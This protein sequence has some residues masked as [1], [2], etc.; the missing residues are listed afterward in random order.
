MKKI[1]YIPSYNY[2]CY[3]IYLNI[4][5]NAKNRF[6]NIFFNT[7]DPLFSSTNKKD[8]KIDEIKKYFDEYCEVDESLINYWN[9]SDKKIRKFINILTNFIKLKKHIEEK[10]DTINPDAILAGTDMGGYTIR[11]CNNWAEKNKIP[12]IIIQTAFFRDEPVDIKTKL[13]NRFFYFLFNTLLSIPLFQRQYL[14]GNEKSNNYLFLWGD[15]FKKLYKGKKIEKNIFITGN[16]AFDPLFKQNSIKTENLSLN[17]PKNKPIITI[18]TQSLNKFLDKK[19]IQEVEI[20]YR[21]IIKDNHDL[22]FIIKIHPREDIKYYKNLFGDINTDNFVIVKNE[23]IYN[24][25]SVTDIQISVVSYSSF[26]AVI[27][28]IPIILVK[29]DLISFLDIFNNEIELNASNLQQLNSSIKKCLTKEYKKKYKKKRV[30]YLKSKL[31]FID[32]KSSYRVMKNIEKI[33]NTYENN[34][35]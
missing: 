10:L 33:V 6:F 13:K 35:P 32:G 31:G 29:K 18:C 4:V 12:F 14:Y 17:L 30:T 20:L 25:Y 15:E 2:L 8:I 21:K 27:F 16:P 22:F 34:F 1:V 19:D 23:D 3:P 26:E 9:N 11:M 28:G 24:I 5:K 7:K